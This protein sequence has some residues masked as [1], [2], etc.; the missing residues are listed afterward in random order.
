MTARPCTTS[1]HPVAPSAQQFEIGNDRLRAIITEVGAGL[2]S[3][4]WDGQELLDTY[5]VGE[6]APGGRG[7]VLAPWPGRVAGG[8][9]T[10][11]NRSHQLPMNEVAHQNAIHGLVRWRRWIPTN[12]SRTT[13]TLECKLHPQPGY[14]FT[15]QLREEYAIVGDSLGVTT[16]VRNLGSDPLPYGVGHHPYFTLGTPRVDDVVLTIPA[17]SHFPIDARGIPLPPAVAVDGSPFDFRAPH[18]VG[19]LVMDECYTDLITRNSWAHVTITTPGSHLALIVALDANHRFLQV[20]TGDTLPE[21]D[22]RRGG[23]AIEPYTCAPNAFNNGCGLRVLQPGER[24]ASTWRIIVSDI[25]SEPSVS[26]SAH[27]R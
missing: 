22:R 18:L 17:R 3:L 8:G 19:P 21:R 26:A 16:A 11:L 14:P 6:T 2:R 20:Y 24:Y 23:I 10:F 5:G 12:H 15:L 27:S 7:Q 13:V 9:Y 25:V 1:P 4:T